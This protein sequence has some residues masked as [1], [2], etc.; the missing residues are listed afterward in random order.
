[1]GYLELVTSC[2]VQQ[3]QLR[4]QRLQER[5]IAVQLADERPDA[6]SIHAPGQLQNSSADLHKQS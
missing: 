5:R 2:E 3:P 4:A 6:I 1:M